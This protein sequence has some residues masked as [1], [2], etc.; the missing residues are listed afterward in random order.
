MF[1]RIGLGYST[2][3]IAF[4]SF[5]GIIISAA[6]FKDIYGYSSDLENHGNAK[7]YKLINTMNF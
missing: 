4:A 3:V 2:L 7:R 5:A 6:I 1:S